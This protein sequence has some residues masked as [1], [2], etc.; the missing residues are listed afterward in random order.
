MIKLMDMG[1][2][3]MLTEIFTRVIGS[4][5]KLMEKEFTHMPMELIIMENGKTINNMV[6]ELKGG[7]TEQFMRGITLK[8]KRMD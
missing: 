6:S 7:Q 5:T 4:M 3:I 2:F 8:V 1:H